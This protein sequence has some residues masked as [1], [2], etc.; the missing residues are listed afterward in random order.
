[1]ASRHNNIQKNHTAILVNLK[2]WF[3]CT[4]IQPVTKDKPN[5]PSTYKFMLGKPPS[6]VQ[7]VP[8]YFRLSAVSKITDDFIPAAG[9][10]PHIIWLRQLWREVPDT[11]LPECR[12]AGDQSTHVG[13]WDLWSVCWCLCRFLEC[14]KGRHILKKG[15]FRCESAPPTVGQ[16]KGSCGKW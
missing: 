12:G 10:Q 14:W 15:S 8:N 4:H 2:I 6:L 13:V 9:I 16:F 7:T 3:L 5:S 1:M 11:L